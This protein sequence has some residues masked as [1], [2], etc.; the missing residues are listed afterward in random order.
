MD[1]GSEGPVG[2][3]LVGAC[4][5]LVLTFKHNLFLLTPV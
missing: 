4:F 1:F 2:G 5:N 3:Q